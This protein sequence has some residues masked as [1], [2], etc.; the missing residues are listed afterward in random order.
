MKPTK[1]IYDS[2]H[3][4]IYFNEW[5]N[6]LIDSAAFQRLHYIRQLGCAYLVYP[7][8]VH[9]R[10][11][12]S[13]GVMKLATEIFDKLKEKETLFSDIT[14]LA[15]WRQML[16]FAALVHDLGHLAFSHS[17]E[18]A[19]LGNGGHEKWTLAI[20]RSAE[21]KSLWEGLQAAY[22]DK[23]PLDAVT[24]IAL[25]ASKLKQIGEEG[26]LFSDWEVVLS[27]MI[28]GDFFGADRIDYLLRD[29]KYTGLSYGFFDY[30]QLIEML[31]ILPKEN[32]GGWVLGVEE[33]GIESCEALLLA[34][35]FMYRRIYEYPSIKA[36]SFHLTCFMI[37]QYGMSDFRRDV[38]SYL[39]LTDNE[40]LSQ[41]TGAAKDKTHPGHVDA[42]AFL[43]RK[44]RFKA[45]PLTDKTSEEKLRAL[46]KTL[47]LS[48]DQIYWEFS[49]N[50]KVKMG[51]NFPVLLK[52][53]SIVPATS[54][55]ELLIPA[56]PQGWLYVDPQIPVE[57]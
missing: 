9:S 2:I 5:E 53:D 39:S 44:K 22:P 41:I 48:E 15:Y 35:H 13:F 36:Y 52:N 32:Q 23:N 49:K 1:R 27:E 28:T 10:F 50:K 46:K 7:G 33:N 19:L 8:A 57:I 17:A 47:Q 56:G 25:G 29:A 43:M 6:Q 42:V 40:V 3:G 34:R 51:L 18:K 16:R 26:Y 30:H 20:M 31:V 45:S 14:D 21:L 37:Q 12:H 11:E 24:K 38:G 55:S 4:F 54:L